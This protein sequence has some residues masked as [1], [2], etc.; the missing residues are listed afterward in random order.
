MNGFEK[1]NPAPRNTAANE[2]IKVPVPIYMRVGYIFDSRFSECK[3][4]PI[5]TIFCI[6]KK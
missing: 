1:K 2:I 4:Q 5:S 6:L 3:I